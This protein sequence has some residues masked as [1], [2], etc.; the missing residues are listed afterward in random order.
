MKINRPREQSTS[1][2]KEVEDFANDDESRELNASS[3]EETKYI[4]RVE[5][6][7]TC[8]TDTRL[9]GQSATSDKGVEIIDNTLDQSMHVM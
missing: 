9:L 2:D 6:V 1:S 8:N 4:D 5:S 7:V 3:V